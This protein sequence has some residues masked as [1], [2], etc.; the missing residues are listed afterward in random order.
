MKTIRAKV[1]DDG[2]VS[3]DYGYDP[4][5][6]ELLKEVSGFWFDKGRKKWV[7]AYHSLAAL[8][9]AIWKQQLAVQVAVSWP[10]QASPVIIGGNLTLDSYQLWGA[11]QLLLR[12]DFILVWSPRV[13]KSATCIAACATGIAT[14][15]FERAVVL[16]PAQ[17]VP[18]W[19][20]ALEKQLPG[21]SRRELVRGL[22]A[23]DV[24]AAHFVFVQH[25]EVASVKKELAALGRLGKFALVLD[26]PQRFQNW[27]A[28]RSQAVMNL[29]ADPHCVRRMGL[30]GTPMR[31]TPDDLAVTFA[32][33]GGLGKGQWGFLKRYSGAREDETIIN[34]HTDKPIWVTGE[35]TNLDELAH[36]L[37]AIS[38]RLTREQVF[39]NSPPIHRTVRICEMSREDGLRYKALEAALGRKALKGKGKEQLTALK[40][41]AATAL[42]VKVDAALARI[43]HHCGERGKKV[44]VAAHWHESLEATA[45]KLTQLGWPHYC[46][47]GWLP[48]ERRKRITADWAADPRPLPLLLNIVASGI[49]IDLSDA[50]G[51][52]VL[53]VPWVPAD[54]LQF[55][56]RIIDVRQGKRTT[57]PWIEYLLSRGTTDEDM[58]LANLRKIATIDVVVGAERESAA[59]AQSLRAS[60]V[61][62]TV[63]LGLVN[64]SDDAV[65]A[66]LEGL[67]RR[68]MEGDAEVMSD[69][70]GT[71]SNAALAGAVAEAFEEDE[72]E[73]HDADDALAAQ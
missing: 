54:A 27:K 47:G 26:E 1:Q 70:H 71:D 65:E 73:E 29:A 5:L 60:G 14:K 66:A 16:T 41:L 72:Q 57:Q 62:D 7:G 34:P 30:T 64:K 19:E 39:P 12:P 24:R 55:E 56:P 46:A 13:G 18:E 58:A 44:L 36:R 51:S 52:I 38:H 40:V 63:D 25:D 69:P 10:L 43:A 21:M 4:D 48:P 28:P 2:R 42:N 15:M 23:A 67:R 9:F 45:A 49:G 37:G 61:V 50:D 33:F 59:L 32:V 3:L 68:L 31:N 20:A 8:Q 53:E 35:P 22:G 17:V 11:A 6:N